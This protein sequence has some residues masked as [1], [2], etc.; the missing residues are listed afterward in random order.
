[1]GRKYKRVFTVEA[2]I[3]CFFCALI[4]G[5]AFGLMVYVA[6]NILWLAFG[7]GLF[8]AYAVLYVILRSSNE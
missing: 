7:L 5:N 2:M 1:M 8:A 4:I 3:V 6:T